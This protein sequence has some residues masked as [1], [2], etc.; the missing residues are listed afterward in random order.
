MA[1]IDRWYRKDG[2]AKPRCGDGLRWQ[3]VWYEGSRQRSQSFGVKGAATRY[4]G[5]VKAGEIAPRTSS[6]LIDD[7]A[8]Q[9]LA[10]K[11]GLAPKTREWY[12]LGARWALDEFSGRQ[13]AS[14]MP[15]EIRLWI[16]GRDAAA[17]TRLRDL[18]ALRAMFDLAIEDGLLEVNPCE[19]VSV[20]R[21]G[22]R[23]PVIL[24]FTLLLE[25]AAA[26]GAYET[27]VR[28]MGTTGVRIGEACALRVGS[29]SLARGRARISRS[30]GSSGEGQT[31]TRKSR[32]V[33][34]PGPVA[35]SL[36]TLIDGRDPGEHL[37]LSPGGYPINSDNWRNRIF[38]PAC[39]AVGIKG[40]HVHDLRHT[41]VSL[42][43]HAGADV[44]AVQEMCGHSS[45]M[46]TLSTYTHLWPGR[47]DE[48]GA[49][50]G[51]LFDS[52]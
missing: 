22:R 28:F 51:A 29:I 40:M 48:V 14:I 41:A 25:L 35:A 2:T 15:S 10:I 3:V 52:M 43:I 31:K 50:M 27:M 36:E 16:A 5:K 37:F 24:E 32:D 21:E 8:A 13:A 26:T 12:E 44:K 23:E 42:A 49:K 1:V 9:L 4:D 30:L 18:Q 20:A 6:V 19:K 45:P 47:I 33:P 11:A 34:V 38:H 39:D 46:I 17:S 7:L